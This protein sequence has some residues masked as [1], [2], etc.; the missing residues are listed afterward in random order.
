MIDDIK[1]KAEQIRFGC[2][3]Q[4]GIDCKMFGAYCSLSE[5]KGSIPLLHGPIG[6]AF[7]PKLLPT[8]AIRQKVLGIKTQPP[9]PCTD[10]DEHDLIYGGIDKLKKALIDVDRYYHPDLIGIVLSCVAGI[11]GEDLKGAVEE[12]KNKVSAKIVIT[13]STG[14][15]DS[16]RSEDLELY[17]KDTIDQ[18]K[19]SKKKRFWGYEKCGRLETI[20][21]LF[22][23]L[24]EPPKKV[25]DRSVNIDLFGRIHFSEDFSLEIN[26]ITTL[27][28]KIGIR[29]NTF[30][31]GCTVKEFQN[32]PQAKLNLM[33]RSE[34]SAKL[35]KE[36]Y[37]TDYI[38]DPFGHKYTGLEGVKK[39]YYD[40]AE[41][42]GLRQ[43]AVE[44]IEEKERELMES[45]K[46]IS[47]ELKGKKV[48]I[49]TSLIMIPTTPQFIQTLELFG[50]EVK[51]IFIQVKRYSWS[52]IPQEMLREVVEQLKQQL[53]DIQS[54][55]EFYVDCDIDTQIE[56]V[57]EKRV[58][59]FLPSMITDM[60]DCLVFESHGIKTLCYGWS[61]YAP[62]KI[63]FDQI[64]ILGNAM[65]EKLNKP[66]KKMNLFYLNYDRD[67]DR[68]PALRSDIPKIELHEEI[69][70]TL[71][72]E[73]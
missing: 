67:K 35:M 8:D 46:L 44:V 73:Q 52:E 71:W 54:D 65:V 3:N 51:I 48:A 40:I 69:L 18:W 26:E 50:L 70:R 34:R 11:I 60:G 9:F 45:I 1:L 13:P 30:F 24:V 23:Q 20:F 29:V 12:V 31:P 15:T 64:R 39:F 16:E 17:I 56:K 68:F 72:R 6:C 2:A 41:Y 63:S 28:N 7:F 59:L 66:I 32:L 21:S 5:I 57:K 19:K 43:K 58:D 27:L 14:F 10:L 42:F 47:S 53:K 36:R 61:G 37:G 4:Y 55:P 33:R 62:Y 22:E 49:G 25:L 38:F